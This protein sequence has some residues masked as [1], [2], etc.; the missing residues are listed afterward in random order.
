MKRN[1]LLVT[2]LA[3]VLSTLFIGCGTTPVGTPVRI[4]GVIECETATGKLSHLVAPT[5]VQADKDFKITF[6][7]YGGG[8]K[9]KG[10]EEVYITENNATVEVYDFTT[11]TS[12]SSVCTMQLKLF[13]HTVTLRFAKPG[14]AII[15]IV[16]Q[17]EVNSGIWRRRSFVREHRLMVTGE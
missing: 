8:S 4:P 10:G 15:K 6:H 1:T 7:T 17:R 11:A 2:L 13:P 5:V 12:L 3:G 16:G 9:S 14:E